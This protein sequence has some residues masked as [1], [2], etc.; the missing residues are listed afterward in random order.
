M[1]DHRV[2]SMGMRLHEM[3]PGCGD[4]QV[5]RAPSVGLADLQPRFREAE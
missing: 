4:V 3:T 1:T 5:W 2:A